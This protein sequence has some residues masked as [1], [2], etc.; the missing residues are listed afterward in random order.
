LKLPP[1]LFDALSLWLIGGAW[2]WC[3]WRYVD[4]VVRALLGRRLRTEVYR[5]EQNIW[6]V[7]RL[8]A[9]LDVSRPDFSPLPPLS[10]G[11]L[12]WRAVFCRAL[13]HA[14]VPLALLFALLLTLYV[15]ALAR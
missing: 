8:A 11:Q 12:W 5:D 4:R 10:D 1:I 6:R 14:L 13:Q 7:R 2:M 3:Y 15:R 9:E